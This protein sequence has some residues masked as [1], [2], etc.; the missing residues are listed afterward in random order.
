MR[1]IGIGRGAGGQFR[2]DE[3]LV[4]PSVGRLRDQSVQQV[5]RRPVGVGRRRHVIRDSHRTDGLYARAARPRGS[6]SSGRLLGVRGIQFAGR[7]RYRTEVFFDEGQRL[8]LF[9][10]A[11]HDQHHVV[12]LIVFLVK[13]LQVFDGHALDVRAVANRRL[14][15]IVPLECR[16]VDP[17]IEDRGR[18]VLAAFKFISHDGHFGEQVFT[19]DEA[20]HQ[21]IAFHSD[22]EFQVFVRGGHRLKVIRAIAVGGA[23]EAGAV[24]AERFGDL[25]VTGRAFENQV[26]QQVRHARFAVAFVAAADEHGHV[27]GDGRARLLGKQEHARPVGELVFGDPLDRRDFRRRFGHRS[28][29]GHED[30]TGCENSDRKNFE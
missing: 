1:V 12:G 16:G 23:V 15:V 26:F 30:Q 14:A 17:L 3:R 9:E 11:G 13:G 24:I 2:F 22:S 8:G 20:V 19:L 4:Q 18:I 21:T 29:R 5:E 7:P 10:P 28:R 27:H 6:P 25:R